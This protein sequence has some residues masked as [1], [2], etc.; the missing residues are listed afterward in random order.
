M[1]PIE[2]KTIVNWVR[3]RKEKNGSISGLPFTCKKQSV[4]GKHPR[5]LFEI[6]TTCLD[7]M[8]LE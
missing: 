8:I 1:Y 7:A 2:Q 3:V 4:R 5:A 6:L